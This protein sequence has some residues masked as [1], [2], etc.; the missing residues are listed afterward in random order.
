M[1]RE[2]LAKL[3]GENVAAER[4]KRFKQSG[5]LAEQ[6]GISRAAMSMIEHGNRLVSLDVLL[7]LAK[8]IGCPVTAL[9]TGAFND[10]EQYQQGYVDGWAAC[11][12]EIDSHLTWS[13]LHMPPVPKPV[14]AESVP[15]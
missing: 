13:P 8:A 14:E 12:S 2:D 7:R 10:D 11:A 5:A 9:L 6:I 1:T 4:T 3:I 15:S